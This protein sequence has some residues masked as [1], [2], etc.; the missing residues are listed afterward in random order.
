MFNLSPT[1]HAS[2][3]QSD[4]SRK[5]MSL[6]PTC[7]DTSDLH[8]P[9]PPVDTLRKK[10][11]CER[12]LW[13]CRWHLRHCSPDGVAESS[14]VSAAS[15]LSATLPDSIGDTTDSVGHSVGSVGESVGKGACSIGGVGHLS[16]RIGGPQPWHYRHPMIPFLREKF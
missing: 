1:L 10:R 12:R 8:V 14:G 5:S 9:I 15:L 7:S 2:I 13:R 6:R 11:R 16:L 3:F 4:S